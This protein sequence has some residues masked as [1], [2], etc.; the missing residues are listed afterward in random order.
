M[1]VFVFIRS[2]L[3]FYFNV[4]VSPILKNESVPVFDF[5][6]EEKN[7]KITSRNPSELV[8]AAPI[9]KNESVPPEKQGHTIIIE[10]R[11]AICTN[12]NV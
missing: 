10:F 3:N 11:V 7:I 12:C 8:R 9:L 2:T 4:H 5:S 6:K 1:T